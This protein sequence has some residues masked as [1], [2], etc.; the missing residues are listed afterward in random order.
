MGLDIPIFKTFAR[1][2][3][4]IRVVVGNRLHRPRTV[5]HK[6]EDDAER[7]LDPERLPAAFAS[8]LTLALPVGG[9]EELWEALNRKVLNDGHGNPF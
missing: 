2:P 4:A 9:H 5:R 6:R 8:V 7:P 1:E 3:N